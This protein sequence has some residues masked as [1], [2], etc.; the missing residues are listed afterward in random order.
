MSRRS[1]AQ[2]AQ[3]VGAKDNFL[4]RFEGRLPG[5]QVSMISLCAFNW[6]EVEFNGM[7]TSCV[8]RTCLCHCFANISLFYQC[9]YVNGSQIHGEYR[10]FHWAGIDTFIY[11]SHHLLTVPPV[12][13][14][15]SGHLHGVPVLGKLWLSKILTSFSPNR[16]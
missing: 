13:W 8:G 10:F 14:I 6:C 11:F 9:R 7:L 5:R 12:A 15:N 2:G 4:S 3:G 1:A 16:K